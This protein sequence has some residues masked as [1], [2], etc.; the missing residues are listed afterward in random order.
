MTLSGVT[1]S[2]ALT[3]VL[4]SKGLSADKAQHVQDELAQSVSASTAA[5]GKVDGTA[6]RAKL[7]QQI[8]A[9][10]ASGKLTREDAATITK[11]LDDA[12]K[13]S[14]TSGASPAAGGAKAAGRSGGGG[15]RGSA[16]TDSSEKT[17]LSRIETIS[18][19][20]KTTTI[21]YTDGTS[22]TTTG[23]ANGEKSKKDQIAQPAAAEAMAKTWLA[24]I[25]PGTLVDTL[26]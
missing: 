15:E 5:D 12:D 6:V 3:S 21:S 8:S 2:N 22:E 19:D 24:K 1:S 25:V 18:G 11:A 4:Q 9:D 10:V 13:A 26:A 14:G 7:D 17:E 20:I 23:P 16:T